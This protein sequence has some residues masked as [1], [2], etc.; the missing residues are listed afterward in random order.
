MLVV[1]GQPWEGEHQFKQLQD[2]WDDARDNPTDKE[3][4]QGLNEPRDRFNKR[5]SEALAEDPQQFAT[6]DSDSPADDPKTAVVD[7]GYPT[8]EGGT[9]LE[10]SVFEQPGLD[11]HFTLPEYDG[12]A[13]VKLY[14]LFGNDLED[15]PKLDKP[16]TMEQAAIQTSRV[17]SYANC[18]RATSAAVMRMKGYDV[19]PYA[20]LYSSLG[21]GL[22]ILTALEM[23]KTPHGSVEAITT[24]G[25]EWESMSARFP[26]PDS[27]YG[28]F[29]F[30]IK[31]A[32]QRHVI[33]WQKRA[34]EIV[35]V[36]PQLGRGI[37]PESAFG[38]AQSGL[39]VLARLDNAD[40]VGSKVS[41]VIQPFTSQEVL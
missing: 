16:E 25:A 32:R 35:F 41:D 20:T 36:D 17:N 12:L 18:V 14:T 26:F 6:F 4:E 30:E 13:E 15:Y 3:L 37:S 31:D 8:D 39:V 5:Y 29:S 33:L 28:V 21:D 40:P 7:N 2:L 38:I 11:G 1:K 27:S 23:W 19:Y 10:G 22:Q 9:G 34:G 24:T